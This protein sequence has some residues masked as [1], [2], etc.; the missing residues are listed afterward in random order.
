MLAG[1]D[2]LQAFLH[3]RHAFGVLGREVVALAG[4]ILEVVEADGLTFGGGLVLFQPGLRL[5][6]CGSRFAVD[7]HPVAV[8][9]G[10]GSC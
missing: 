5:L 7:E 6:S 3:F 4:I 9:Q 2:L 10:E 1:A 8:A